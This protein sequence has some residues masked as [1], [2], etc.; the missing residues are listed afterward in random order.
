MWKH[1]ITFMNLKNQYANLKK[2]DTKLIASPTHLG[3]NLTKFQE[4]VKDRGTWRAVVYG[5]PNCQT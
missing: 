2:P 3:I 5:V 1:T 4:I